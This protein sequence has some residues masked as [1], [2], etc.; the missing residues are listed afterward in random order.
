MILQYFVHI[1]CQCSCFSQRYHL[2]ETGDDF[3]VFF[4]SFFNLLPIWL[5][6]TIDLVNFE[7]PT[8]CCCYFLFVWHMYKKWIALWYPWL[9]YIVSIQKI[10]LVITSNTEVWHLLVVLLPWNF[11]NMHAE[12]INQ[13]EPLHC[14]LVTTTIF[15]ACSIH[16]HWYWFVVIIVSF[17][18]RFCFINYCRDIIM[19]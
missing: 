17:D 8:I 14:T 4:F 1:Q 10:Q 5:R 19:A 18:H 11:V 2:L 7:H 3:I 16:C 13:D 12:D 9:L 15:P 6:S